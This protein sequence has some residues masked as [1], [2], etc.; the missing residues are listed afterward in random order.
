MMHL[1]SISISGSLKL[2]HPEK[3]NAM[4]LSGKKEGN[5]NRAMNLKALSSF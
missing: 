3:H 4:P 2:F 5:S 1:P